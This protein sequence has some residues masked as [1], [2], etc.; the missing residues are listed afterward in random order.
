MMDKHRSKDNI[1]VDARSTKT[2]RQRQGVTLIEVMFAIFVVVVGLA[3]IASLLPLAA[4]NANDSNAH[5]TAQALGQHWFN[6]FFSYHLHEPT[7][8]RDSQVGYNW[9]W[10]QDFGTPGFQLYDRGRG[11]TPSGSA[12]HN[13]STAV[14]MWAHQPVCLDPMFFTEPEVVEHINRNISD[15]AVYR[16]SVFPYYQDGYNPLT[17][18]ATV[19]GAWSDQPRMVRATLGPGTLPVSRKLI[20]DMFASADDLAIDAEPTDKSL[21]PFRRFDASLSK[22]LLS[23]QYSWLAT[24]SPREP[25]PQHV[26]S[27]SNAQESDLLANPPLRSRDALLSVVVM[28]RR[29]RLYLTPGLALTPGTKEDK[30]QGERLVWVVPLSGDFTGGNGGRVRLV[31][32]VD[33]ES[34]LHT[35]DWIM[36]G[37]HYATDRVNNSRRYSYF[38]WYRILGMGRD[39]G[40]TSATDPFGNEATV[41]ARDV[42]LE[43]PDFDMSPND[44][45]TGV[46]TPVTG[47]IV[48]GVVTVIERN[49]Q[50]R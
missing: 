23:G 13:G 9:L 25:L 5:N 39:P 45:V 40:I 24:I 2:S 18:P 22:G 46:P 38:R 11:L 33:T 32:H 4:R 6:S 41:W 26:R 12:L 7:A 28:N 48:N 42:I 17:D 15:Q 43:G 36:L 50:L 31:G 20:E 21:P 3:G 44:F 10:R 37:K 30:P 1:S 8:F 16:L 49:I 47:T 35:G 19:A 27:I 34:R 14:R 29:D